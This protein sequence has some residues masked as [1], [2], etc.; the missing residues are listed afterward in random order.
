M[1]TIIE[2]TLDD[3]LSTIYEDI[4]KMNYKSTEEALQIILKRVIETMLKERP[5]DR[6]E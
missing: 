2:H 3:D 4:A 1:L 5:I 6:A